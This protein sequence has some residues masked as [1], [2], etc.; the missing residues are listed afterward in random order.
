M[1]ARM[2]AAVAAQAVP[3][4]AA[5]SLRRERESIQEERRLA[6]ELTSRAE[7][8]AQRRRFEERRQAEERRRLDE[9]RAGEARAHAESAAGLSRW[10]REEVLGQPSAGAGGW[11]PACG[12]ATKAAAAQEPRRLSKVP[13]PYELLAQERHQELYEPPVAHGEPEEHEYLVDNSALNVSAPGITYRLSKSLDDRDEDSA[14]VPWG[15]T[16][17][18]YDAGDGWL[19][20]GDRFLPM[21]VQGIPVLVRCGGAAAVQSHHEDEPAHHT[22]GVRAE[23]RA[24]AERQAQEILQAIEGKKREELK[25]EAMAALEAKKAELAAMRKQVEE[26]LEAKRRAEWAAGSVR[27]PGQDLYTVLGLD[28]HASTDDITRAYRNLSK[29]WHPDKEH[30]AQGRDGLMAKLNAAREVLS[31]PRQRWKY[32][33][34]LGPDAAEAVAGA[35]ATVAAASGAPPPRTGPAESEVPEDFDFSGGGQLCRLSQGRASRVC[36]DCGSLRKERVR[37]AMAQLRGKEEMK[38]GINEED[39]HRHGFEVVRHAGPYSPFAGLGESGESHRLAQPEVRARLR[40]FLVRRLGEAQRAGTHWWDERG[41]RYASLGSGLLLFDLELLERLRLEGIRVCHISLIDCTYRQPKVDARRA[42]R[43]FADWQRCAAQMLK[44][45][46]ADILAFGSLGH[47]FQAAGEGGVAAGCHLLLHCDAHWEGAI[48]DC[49]RLAVRALV[50]GGLLVRL[51]NHQEQHEMPSTL[52]GG[53]LYKPFNGDASQDEDVEKQSQH[54]GA[55]QPPSGAPFVLS[56]WTVET[57]PPECCRLPSL[58]VLED[59]MLSKP[60]KSRARQRAEEAGLRLWRVTHQPRV[61]VRAAPSASAQVV[62][63]LYTGDEVLTTGQAEGSWLRVAK[64][65]WP[66]SAN[67]PE[68]AWLLR[69]GK[70]MGLGELLEL[71]YSPAGESGIEMASSL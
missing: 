30:G 1:Q 52:K 11:G 31:S 8:G 41:L 33:R 37:L 24:Q 3:L 65:S 14:V 46:A 44:H 23:W 29:Q 15:T 39:T 17:V 12:A 47:F 66:D 22:A 4:N 27:G 7:A 64:A 40:D 54:L 55:V 48:E 45:K 57:W 63:V 18:G 21:E 51:T 53:A 38:F 20:V 9:G 61:A 10:L 71:L 16:C 2:E 25:K 59:P 70:S 62:E 56:A 34:S 13:V 32:D 43:E 6:Q 50:S 49:D 42:L 36:S 5:E 58:R 19:K 68:E 35:A 69:E 67:A 60:W 28:R 26:E